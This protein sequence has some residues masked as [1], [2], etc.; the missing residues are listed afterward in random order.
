MVECFILRSGQPRQLPID[1]LAIPPPR[2]FSLDPQ[3]AGLLTFG[4]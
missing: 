1:T 2:F 3:A 4:N